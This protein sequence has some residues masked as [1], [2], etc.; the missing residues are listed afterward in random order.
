MTSDT[1][2]EK[3]SVTRGR[4]RSKSVEEA[5][6]RAASELMEELKFRDIT[7]EAI[8]KR[9]GVG[10]ATL[11]KWWPNKTHILVDA[12]LRQ[13]VQTIPLPDTGS[14]LE[15][16][17]ILLRGFIAFHK[18]TSFGATVTQIFAEA[19]LDPDLMHI[20]AE[21]Y[22]LPRRAHLKHIWKRG[23]ERGDI[24]PDV[25][26]DLVLDMLYGVAIYRYLQKHA[27][28]TPDTAQAIVRTAF[29]GF[30]RPSV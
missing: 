1:A 13:T 26:P 18:E 8:A 27:E 12:V 2:P 10:K 28:I 21:R 30:G 14:A 24:R 17:T 22:V 23:V 5:I 6:V 29:E 4:P 20:Y 11:Y 19:L 16:F 9:A 3:T 15:D 7:A 25:D